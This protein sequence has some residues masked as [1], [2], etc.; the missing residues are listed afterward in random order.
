MVTIDGC[1]LLNDASTFLAQWSAL[2]LIGT[3]LA[4]CFN[5]FFVS[6]QRCVFFFQGHKG[7]TLEIH[8]AVPYGSILFH[9]YHMPCRNSQKCLENEPLGHLAASNWSNVQKSDIRTSQS[10]YNSNGQDRRVLFST[11]FLTIVKGP[12]RPVR[13][14]KKQTNQTHRVNSQS[15]SHTPFKCHLCTIYCIALQ[16]CSPQNHDRLGEITRA[17]TTLGAEPTTGGVPGLEYA[18]GKDDEATTTAG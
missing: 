5:F 18:T 10:A 14:S 2:K 1:C 15:T 16:L 13:L 7:N 3:R 9:Q 4:Q 11:S 6:E 12:K 17:A 8:C